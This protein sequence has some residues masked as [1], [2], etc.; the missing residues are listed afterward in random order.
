MFCFSFVSYWSEQQEG[1]AV[2]NETV[3]TTAGSRPSANGG[4][5]AASTA[6]RDAVTDLAVVHASGAP[7]LV[8]ADRAGVVKVFL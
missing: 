3:E 6:H 7:M 1:V 5:V 4:L 2:L 8:S